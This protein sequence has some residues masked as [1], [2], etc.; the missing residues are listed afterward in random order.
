MP[1]ENPKNTIIHFFHS[2]KY[3]GSHPFIQATK[4]LLGFE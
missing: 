3:L 4:K 1:P 2:V